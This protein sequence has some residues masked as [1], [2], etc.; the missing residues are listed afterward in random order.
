MKTYEIMAFTNGVV[1]TW[2]FLISVDIILKIK[3]LIEFNLNL[4]FN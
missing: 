3:L 2:R 4:N 1:S